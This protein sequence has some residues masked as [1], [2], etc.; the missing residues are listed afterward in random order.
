MS[1]K[2]KLKLARGAIRAVLMRIK[3]NAD[4]RH[5]IGVGTDTFNS[6]C[7][8]Y[9][10]LEDDSLETIMEA[11]IPGSSEIL[12]ASVQETLEAGA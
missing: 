5:H 3:E 7:V 10:V 4:V 1:S 6:L 12:H 8:A 9:A 2:D 11:V